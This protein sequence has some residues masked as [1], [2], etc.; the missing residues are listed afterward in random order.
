MTRFKVIH[1][2]I[3][4]DFVKFYKIGANDDAINVIFKDKKSSFS[5]H[6]NARRKSELIEGTPG[7]SQRSGNS[8]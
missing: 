2:H 7:T 6:H 3:S 5:R 4:V 1:H 8:E